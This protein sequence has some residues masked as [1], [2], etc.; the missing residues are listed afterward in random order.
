MSNE[1]W[2]RLG[3]PS[4]ARST[5]T[6]TFGRACESRGHRYR[7]ALRHRN[8]RPSLRGAG[9]ARRRAAPW[10]VRVRDLGSHT[11]AAA[12]RARSS[13]HQAALLRRHGQGAAVCL[14]NQSVAGGRLRSAQ[15]S[16]KTSCPSSCPRGS[17]PATRPS[18]RASEAAPRA[19]ADM[20]ARRAASGASVLAAAGTS[21]GA[22]SHGT[23]CRRSDLRERLEAAVS[24]HLMSDVPLGV[25][26]SG[27]IDSSA[28]AALVARAQ[29]E[30]APDL[31]R[32]ASPNR[33]ANELPYARLAA[34]HIGAEHHE[35][36]VTPSE[37]FRSPAPR[38]LARRRAHCVSVEHPTLYL[39][40][41]LAREHVKVV[42]TGEGADELFLGYNRYRVTQLERAS[43]TAVLGGRCPPPCR[44]QVRRAV[45]AL[46]ASPRPRGAT[47]VCRARARHPWSV[48]RELRRLSSAAA[49]APPPAPRDVRVPRSLRRRNAATTTRRPA[50][51]STGSAAPTSRRTCSSC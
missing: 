44:R 38:A 45:H 48:S 10:H 28:L 47:H 25:F 13:G 43:G 50:D 7:T 1:D 17:C 5:T 36:T 3:R 6:L 29:T 11:P 35:V 40:A 27:G 39:L 31:R 41:R 2:R 24:S 14:G 51:C 33:E 19:C 49:A 8:H 15:R 16:T 37:F 12:A 30:T 4:T 18:S 42:L 22:G 46:P 20:V 26:L 34:A 32:R 23:L 21:R 9:R